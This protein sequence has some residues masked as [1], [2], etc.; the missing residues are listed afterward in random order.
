[1]K[2]YKAESRDPTDLVADIVNFASREHQKMW[3]AMEHKGGWEDWAQVELAY[4]INS[5]TYRKHDYVVERELTV[6]NKPS[7]RIDIWATSN[8]KGLPNIGIELK[9]E[10]HYQDVVTNTGLQARLMADMVKVHILSQ[11]VHH[12][13]RPQVRQHFKGST[14]WYIGRTHTAS[15]RC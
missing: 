1:M 11:L 9:C 6:Y 10:G 8:T 2:S 7:Q 5:K 4:Y 13:V 15:A 3:E 12:Q 14:G